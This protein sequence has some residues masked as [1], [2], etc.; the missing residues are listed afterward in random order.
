MIPMRLMFPQHSYHNADT[1]TTPPS[2]S[3]A[4]AQ[5]VL[6][7]HPVILFKNSKLLVQKFP[8]SLQYSTSH[9]IS[10]SMPQARHDTAMVSFQYRMAW[11]HYGEVTLG[12]FNQDSNKKTILNPRNGIVKT[13]SHIS[14]SNQK[15]TKT[16]LTHT[17]CK[18]PTWI[19][20]FWSQQH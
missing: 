10:E 7:Q 9:A 17:T 18:L 2:L 14:S 5:V 3:T 15:Q 19:V 4:A 13:P 1:C 16:I 12:A 20:S 8:C 6:P 11:M